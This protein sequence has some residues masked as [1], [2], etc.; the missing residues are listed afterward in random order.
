[1]HSLDS[2]ARS[3]SSLTMDFNVVAASA[4]HQGKRH[5]P[6]S[7]LSALWTLGLLL[8]GTI[9][10][11]ADDHG[12][13]L[14]TATAVNVP[15]TT[16]GAIHFAGDQDCFR[17]TITCTQ[18]IIATTAGTTDTFG[19]LLDSAGTTLA[20]NDNVNADKNFYIARSL[21]AGTY[22][23]RV[24][25]CRSSAVSGAY[26]VNLKGSIGA[27]VMVIKGNGCTIASG[28]ITP[29]VEDN[30][31]F[32]KLPYIGHHMDHDFL[33]QNLGNAPLILNDL[34]MS[35]DSHFK[36][37]S[38]PSKVVAPGGS[39]SFRVRFI[40]LEFGRRASPLST[41]LLIS[42]NAAF[43]AGDPVYRF[44]MSGRNHLLTEDYG[45]TFAAAVDLGV[46]EFA[47]NDPFNLW[48]D[49][50][51]WS[52]SNSSED[53]DMFKFS[54]VTKSLRVKIWSGGNNLTDTFGTLYNSAGAIM[55]SDDNSAGNGQFFM[56]R[57]L[58]RGDYYISVKAKPGPVMRI[59]EYGLFLNRP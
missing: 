27:P 59:Q 21:R 16:G 53:L 44:R 33:I 48:R 2:I 34:S 13:T 32:G 41:D 58:P 55:A 46:L 25:H 42:H 28:D 36:I 23:L 22:Y 52:A 31:D 19:A 30:T 39:S 5:G 11:K 47:I 4:P 35:L 54:V 26:Q 38:Q 6:K 29:S 12:N 37:I 14:S 49:L 24:S 17:F 57:V 56:D 9:A 18:N 1:M 50:F 3:S 45:D 15:S 7:R 20:F 8:F 43:G 51:V 10:A 40:P